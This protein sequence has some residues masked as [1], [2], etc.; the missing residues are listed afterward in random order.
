MPYTTK[1][2]T[3]LAYGDRVLHDG[4]VYTVVDRQG[5]VS[6]HSPGRVGWLL[7]AADRRVYRLSLSVD[8]RVEVT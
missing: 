7:E 4:S 5:I 8:D 3:E 2:A 6:S 1:K